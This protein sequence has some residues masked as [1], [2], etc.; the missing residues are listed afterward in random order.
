MLNLRNIYTTSGTTTFSQTATAE[1]STIFFRKP[2][3]PFTDS[4][5]TMT[6]GR[7]ESW[8]GRSTRGMGESRLVGNLGAPLAYGSSF[9]SLSEEGEVV[10]PTVEGADAVPREEYDAEDA[11]QEVIVIHANPLGADLVEQP[12]ET[13]EMV[14]MRTSV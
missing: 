4:S 8:F 9:G 14:E 7:G 5:A 12:V 13:R 3:T 1:T 6:D 11:D 10:S 2:Q